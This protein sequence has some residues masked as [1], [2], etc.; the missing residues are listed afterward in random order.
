[1]RC[2]A[3][4]KSRSLPSR[5]GCSPLAAASHRVPRV[6]PWSSPSGNLTPYAPALLHPQAAHHRRFVHVQPGAALMEYFHY[7]LLHHAA[8]ARPPSA[9]STNRARAP[10]RPRRQSRVLAGPQV[11]LTLG[12]R[13]PRKTRPQC[14]QRSILSLSGF[15]HQGGRAAH[16]N[17]HQENSGWPDSYRS[18]RSAAYPVALVSGRRP[19]CVPTVGDERRHQPHRDNVY[20]RVSSAQCKR[21][22]RT[23]RRGPGI[24]VRTRQR[25]VGSGPASISLRPGRSADRA[26]HLE[27]ADV[28]EAR[29]RR[30]AVKMSSSKR[31]R[32]DSARA[33]RR[34]TSWAR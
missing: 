8:G 23:A 26:Q 33:R 31:L 18:Q 9:N 10:F 1:M 32:C 7:S 13:A 28:D 11:K 22:L 21:I 34:W 20:Q 3:Q 27:Y 25:R 30:P 12:L 16:G 17:L 24:P 15:I 5:R 2:S 19:A 29:S 6:P 14:Q 4:S